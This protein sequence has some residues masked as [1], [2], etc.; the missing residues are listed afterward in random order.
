L[1]TFK[2]QRTSGS[3]FFKKP[4]R[5]GGFHETT[6]KEPAVLYK[7]INQFYIFLRTAVIY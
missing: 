1:E 2:N 3:R 4:Q 6:S 7:I 5:T